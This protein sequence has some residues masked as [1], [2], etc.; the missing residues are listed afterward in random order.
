MLSVIGSGNPPELSMLDSVDPESLHL[1]KH[2]NTW[3]PQFQIAP[4]ESDGSHLPPEP[5]GQN[6]SHVT[7]LVAQSC[8]TLRDP[9]DCSLPGSSVHGIFQVRITGVGNHSLIQRILLTQ[10]LNP[11]LLYCRQ[12]LGGSVVKNPPANPGD[13]RDSGFDPWGRKIPWSREWQPAPV[14]LP[15]KFHGQRSLAG[16]S[17]WGCKE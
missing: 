3:F 16:Y 10:G 14:F 2:L 17:P 9:M 8:P 1:V 11:G 13:I 4:A 5:I 6:Q 15:G 12:I 7:V